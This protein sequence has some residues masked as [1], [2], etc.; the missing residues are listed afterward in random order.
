MKIWPNHQALNNYLFLLFNHPFLS[1]NY[2]K[3]HLSLSFILSL[4]PEKWLEHIKFKSTEAINEVKFKLYESNH[5]PKSKFY[6][7]NIPIIKKEKHV[8]NLSLL[9]KGKPPARYRRRN[10]CPTQKINRKSFLISEQVN[11]HGLT[12]PKFYQRQNLRT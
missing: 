4:Y 12:R 6:I 3:N 5:K 1:T 11:R 9:E 7:L 2:Q 10:Q 8:Q